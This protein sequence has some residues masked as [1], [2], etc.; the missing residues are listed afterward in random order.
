MT[1]LPINV[2]PVSLAEELSLF[3]IWKTDQSELTFSYLTGLFIYQGH[4]KTVSL[5]VTFLAS[6][7]FRLGATINE[8]REIFTG[9]YVF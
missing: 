5:T 7:E 6:S 1:S 4:T 3:Y 8:V 9:P 2:Y